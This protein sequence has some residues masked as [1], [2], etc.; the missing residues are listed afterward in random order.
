MRGSIVLAAVYWAPSAQCTGGVTRPFVPILTAMAVSA[1]LQKPAIAA[2]R[3]TG[4]MQCLSPG[5]PLIPLLKR[6]EAA[7]QEETATIVSAAL[8]KPCQDA[9]ELE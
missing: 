9:Q 5:P 4:N 7:R 6:L 2:L 8:R 1:A 3:K